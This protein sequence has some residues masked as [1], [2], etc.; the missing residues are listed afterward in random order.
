MLVCRFLAANL[1]DLSRLHDLLCLVSYCCAVGPVLFRYN[2]SVVS[3]SFYVGGQAR[4]VLCGSYVCMLV[5]MGS[6][7]DFLFFCVVL[8]FGLRFSRGGGVG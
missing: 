6:G 8:W 2:G 7:F 5:Y 3:V 4:A 1:H